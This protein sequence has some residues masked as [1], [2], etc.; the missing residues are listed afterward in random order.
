MPKNSE[1]GSRQYS[2]DLPAVTLVDQSNDI[3]TRLCDL[4]ND[5]ATDEARLKTWRQ[6]ALDTRHGGLSPERA[7]QLEIAEK[8]LTKKIRFGKDG[9]YVLPENPESDEQK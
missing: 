7:K 8:I 6:L 4:A 9:W 1:S 3:F 2:F 5:L